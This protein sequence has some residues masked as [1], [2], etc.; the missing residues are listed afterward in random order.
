MNWERADQVSYLSYDMATS[1]D[2]DQVLGVYGL[3]CS[4]ILCFSMR[5]STFL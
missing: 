2:L 1:F 3:S 4:E 5:T